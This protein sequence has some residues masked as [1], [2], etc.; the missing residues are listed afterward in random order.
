MGFHC[1]IPSNIYIYIC[2]YIYIYT[3]I[4]THLYIHIEDDEKQLGTP[5]LTG[6]ARIRDE[7]EER[8]A[9]ARPRPRPH[10]R[11][12]AALAPTFP[13]AGHPEGGNP[14]SSLKSGWY[15]SIAFTIMST[16]DE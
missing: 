3:Y 13:E 2:T 12:G 7:M 10:G 14:E 4:Y 15:I 5:S 16:L 6:P 8:L 1:P 9:L 11:S